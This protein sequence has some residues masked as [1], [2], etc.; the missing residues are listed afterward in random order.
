MN[1]ARQHKSRQKKHYSSL[2]AG[3]NKIHEIVEIRISNRIGEREGVTSKWEWFDFLTN[4]RKDQLPLYKEA[5]RTYKGPVKF[6]LSNKAYGF[7]ESRC[8]SFYLGDGYYALYVS[9]VNRSGLSDFW[10]HFRSLSTRRD[11]EK[12]KSG[13]SIYR[14]QL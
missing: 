3:W 8:G 5:I 4:F 11:A 14:N 2:K 6:G 13:K 10:A 9:N 1:T 7:H 12:K